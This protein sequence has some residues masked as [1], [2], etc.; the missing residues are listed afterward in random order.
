M[1]RP[2]AAPRG[3]AAKRTLPGGAAAAAFLRRKGGGPPS[4]TSEHPPHLRKVRRFIAGLLSPLELGRAEDQRGELRNVGLRRAAVVAAR[5]CDLF[6][7]ELGRQDRPRLTARLAGDEPA[8]E[9]V[10]H[11]VGRSE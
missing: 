7:G 11:C 8:E 6:T 5:G 1:M 2:S 4:A 9:P 10:Q 3:K